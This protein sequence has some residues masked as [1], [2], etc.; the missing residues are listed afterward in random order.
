MVVCVPENRAR[1]VDG[2]GDAASGS[3]P[4]TEQGSGIDDIAAIDASFGHAVRLLDSIV[5]GD[6]ALPAAEK[7]LLTVAATAVRDPA[8]C[9]ATVERSV[10]SGA[11]ASQLG[12]VALA[13]Y[14]SR[15]AAP[16]RVVVEAAAA[17]A[18][19][20]A[21]DLVDSRP[22]PQTADDSRLDAEAI[23]A[24]FAA[25]FG[26]VPDRALLL[27]EHAPDAL[28]AYHRMRVAVLRDG[29]LSHRLAELVLF[30]VNAAEHRS[31]FAAVHARGARLAGASEAELV[32][33]GVSAV[34]VGGVAAWLSAS[35]AIVATRQP[36]PASAM[37]DAPTSTVS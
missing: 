37:P 29:A 25:V 13:L 34:P 30:C 14:L 27:A 15:G 3:A 4:A 35:E 33:A 23:L 36:D 24:E 11:T 1:I 16:A 17:I 8:R 22:R 9:A 7:D 32:E 12:A 10:G 2:M 28:E 5:S 20:P 19:P 6:G 31:D 21:A 26:D 18:S